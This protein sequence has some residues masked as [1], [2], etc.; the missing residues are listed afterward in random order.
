MDGGKCELNTSHLSCLPLSG[1]VPLRY[2]KEN[3]HFAFFSLGIHLGFGGIKQ[4][5]TNQSKKNKKK[6]SKTERIVQS[7]ALLKDVSLRQ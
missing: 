5:L 6:K 4:K 7:V 1:S 2:F 3:L